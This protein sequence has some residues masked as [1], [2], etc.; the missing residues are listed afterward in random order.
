M[1]NT[2]YYM[3]Y[4]ATAD[5][6]YTKRYVRNKISTYKYDSGSSDWK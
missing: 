5:S 3:L 2:I 4:K 6:A 1:K